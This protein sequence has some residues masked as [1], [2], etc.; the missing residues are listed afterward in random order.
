MGAAAGAARAVGP[1]SG[2]AQEQPPGDDTK[3]DIPDYS[4][5]DQGEAQAQRLAEAAG[6]VH[7]VSLSPDP[8]ARR[9]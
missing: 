2:T 9:H 4:S 6:A 3:E 1:D 7:S 5:K 8:G